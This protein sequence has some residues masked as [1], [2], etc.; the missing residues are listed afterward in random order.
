MKGKKRNVVYSTERGDLRSEEAR[1]LPKVKSVPPEEQTPAIRREKKGRG[2][3]EVTVIYDL[4]LAPGEMKTLAKTLKKKCG[5]GGTIKDGTI[6]IQGDH[7]ETIAAE[8]QHL[9]YKT[10]FT[11][12]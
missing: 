6:E 1:R 8:L 7:R 5:T 4:Q 12:G 2:G 3:K 10:K 11:G 9:G